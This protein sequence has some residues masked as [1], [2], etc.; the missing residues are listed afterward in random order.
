MSDARRTA[1][2]VPSRFP[3]RGQSERPVYYRAPPVAPSLKIQVSSLAAPPPCRSCLESLRSQ[4]Q[5]RPL[6]VPVDRQRLGRQLPQRQTAWFLA[7]H[8]G[9]D[10]VRGERGQAQDSCDV[11]AVDAVLGRNRL[12]ACRQAAIQHPLPA[13]GSRQGQD[14]RPFGSALGLASLGGGRMISLRPARIL[15]SI[16]T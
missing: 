1:R 7:S 15:N 2:R 3:K 6:F 11:G 10:E 12:D 4:P 5:R 8:D 9:G 16:G 14:Q 13:V